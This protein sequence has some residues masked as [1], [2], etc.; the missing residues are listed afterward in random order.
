[1]AM[2]STCSGLSIL[3]LLNKHNSDG[4]KPPRKRLRRK[5]T[6][7]ED[8]VIRAGVMAYGVQNWELIAHLLEDRNSK[9]CR[10]RYFM[11]LIPEVRNDP[12]SSEEDAKL[13]AMV[14]Q[15][16]SEWAKISRFFRGRSANNIKNRWHQMMKRQA[17]VWNSQN[18]KFA[19]EGNARE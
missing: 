13:V 3:D 7:E 8:A 4:P 10:E 14:R 15:L 16:G 5:F 6:P 1:M 12:W 17:T 18:L 11:Y 2:S 9:Q 19:N